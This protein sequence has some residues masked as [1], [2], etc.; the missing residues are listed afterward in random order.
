MHRCSR[1][2]SL[3]RYLK[4][5]ILSALLASFSGLHRL[6]SCCHGSGLADSYHSTHSLLAFLPHLVLFCLGTCPRRRANASDQPQSTTMM[7]ILTKLRR[8]SIARDGTMLNESLNAK[9][10]CQGKMTSRRSS[11]IGSSSTRQTGGTP[12]FRLLLLA[13]LPLLLD[14]FEASQISGRTLMTTFSAILAQ[15]VR[16]TLQRALCC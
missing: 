11:P 8:R 6:R 3:G 16:C 5:L 14:R 1:R 13:S 2:C 7:R 12:S 10:A 4:A 9:R 15:D